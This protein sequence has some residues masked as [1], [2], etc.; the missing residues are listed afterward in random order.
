[1]S[2]AINIQTYPNIFD[3][4]KNHYQNMVAD[5]Q[6]NPSRLSYQRFCDITN[7]AKC[8]LSCANQVQFYNAA[9]AMRHYQS[10]MSLLS[11]NARISGDGSLSLNIIDYGCGQGLATLA[12]FDFI[13]KYIIHDMVRPSIHVHLIEP[14]SIT[15]AIA[16]ELV[17]SRAH[18]LGFD[19]VLTSQNTE[20]KYTRLP[21]SMKQNDHQTCHLFCNV[22]DI[23]EVQLSLE[24]VVR[25][26]NDIGGQSFVLA[27]SPNYQEARKGFCHLSALWM[28]N[29]NPDI[30]NKWIEHYSYNITQNLW[31]NQQA[32]SIQMV[33][34]QDE[35]Y[36]QAA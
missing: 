6:K 23:I 17:T 28:H 11:E 35:A 22:L 29:A 20:L 8:P 21:N 19:L 24:P 25:E 33:L 2:N 36:R 16:K 12:M 5:Y 10:F 34:V 14:S 31:L 27:C 3:T 15:L 9:F 26:M 4:F 30:K 13:A 18:A 1:M 7:R 32:K